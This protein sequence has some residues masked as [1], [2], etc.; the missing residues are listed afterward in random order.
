M[1]KLGLACI[2]GMVI[3]SFVLITQA[4][5][6]AKE[7]TTCPVMGAAINKN[8]YVDHNGKRVYF[9]CNAC[10]AAFKKDPE[11]YIKKLE[12]EG[13]VLEKAPAAPEKK[14]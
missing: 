4:P 2:I 3:V 6:W 1:K 7:Q 10:P 14:M 13:V 5:V 11:K 12:G 9:C 8:I